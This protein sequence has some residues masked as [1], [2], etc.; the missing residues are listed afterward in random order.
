MRKLIYFLIGLM[1]IFS[2]EKEVAEIEFRIKS[3]GFFLED[4]YFHPGDSFPSFSHKLSGGNVS[5]ISAST[6]YE[7]RTG[8][9]S[10]EDF[11]FELP[12]GQYQ[13]E[14]R[15][16]DASLYGQ[17]G[18]SFLSKPT[19]ITVSELMEP[20]VNVNVEANCALLL[21]HDELQ[22]LDNGIY[23]IE[24]YASYEGYFRSYPLTL[25]S[26]S[27][28]YFAYF[29]PDTIFSN[30]SAYIWFYGRKPGAS[31]GGLPTGDFEKGYQYLIKVLD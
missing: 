21:V 4:S 3:T 31:S 15:I 19:S 14:F 26:I 30:P 8:R 29:T 22:E 25:D 28:L 23:M 24:N 18:G 10:I 16:P 1:F 5:F 6:S 13:M 7:F 12:A 2:C 20:E 17:K 27:G 9:I 11:L